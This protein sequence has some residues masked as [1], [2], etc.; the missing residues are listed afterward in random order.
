MKIKQ[1]FEFYKTKYEFACTPAG[2][3]AGFFVLIPFLVFVFFLTAYFITG[4][5]NMEQVC[6]YILL[7]N[8]S[9]ALVGTCIAQLQYGKLVDDY[10]KTKSKK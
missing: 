5:S 6:R 4:G 10:I 1:F 8:A 2:V 9:I 7:T 3:R